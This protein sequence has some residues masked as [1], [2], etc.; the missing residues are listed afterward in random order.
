MPI[1]AIQLKPRLITTIRSLVQTFCSCCRFGFRLPQ[2][3]F[4]FVF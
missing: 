3:F 4:R 1:N 2:L